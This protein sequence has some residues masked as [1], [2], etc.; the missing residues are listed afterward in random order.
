MAKVNFSHEYPTLQ[1]ID[2]A[3]ELHQDKKTRSYLGMSGIGFPCARR[4][5]LDF[6][7]AS[8]PF[9]EAVTLR[10]FDDGHRSEA[11]MADRLR[12]VTGVTLLTDDGH[13]N[14]IGAIDHFGHVRGHVDGMILGI[15]EAPKSWHVWEHKSVDDKKKNAL[16]KLVNECEETA[17][18]KWN[19]D[20]FA[21]AQYY[22]LTM[23]AKRH[24][25]TVS[26]PGCRTAI[27]VRTHYDSVKAH[28]YSQRAL[29]IVASDSPPDR[30]ASD[31]EYF[32]CQYS[33]NHMAQC[34]DQQ[35]PQVNCRTCLHSAPCLQG[36]SGEWVCTRH[37]NTLDS[38]L[39]ERA[40]GDH[41]FI[42]AML[43]A[44]ALLCD[45]DE[46]ANAVCYTNAITGKVFWNGKRGTDY[47]SLEIL[48][49]ADKALIGDDD[50]NL[51]KQTFDGR[52]Q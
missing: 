28:Q 49:C 13:G 37:K 29:E 51:F 5:W 50:I 18:E 40:C 52:L 46:K 32:L 4:I 21:Q 31:K 16:E 48:A 7:K 20:Y 12:M 8:I 35:S 19:G 34:H 44:W 3:M 47:T 33:C 2:R 14:Q 9:F 11:I 6:R 17:L 45:A 25:L 23:K 22:M 42:P 38:E 30:I 27:S 43:S 36:D 15:L 24:F 10:K 41:L 1:A 39:Q 26:S